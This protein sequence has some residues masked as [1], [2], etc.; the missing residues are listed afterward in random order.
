MIDGKLGFALIGCG[1]VS[2]NHLEAV[3]RPDF[4]GRLAAV[5]DLDPAKA[6][7]KSAKHGGVPAYTDFREML[8]K[9]P[10]VDVVQIA[11]PTGL[12][13]AHVV[14]VAKYGRHIVVEKPMALRVEDAKAMI[15]AVKKAK[16]RLFVVKQNRFNTAVQAAR[17]ALD[18]GRLGKLVMA[19]ARVRWRREQDYYEQDDWHGTW[20]LD[21]GV[22]SQQASHHLDLLQWFLGGEVESVRC[23]AATRLLD[24][25]VEDTAAATLLCKGGA[26]GVF[27]ATVCA[28]PDDMEAS[29]SLLGEKGSV[30]I[31]GKAVNKIAH[32]KFAEPRADDADIVQ[33]CSSEIPD[34][35]GHGH[36][37]YLRDVAEKIL[38]GAPAL[39]EG[40]EG[41]RNVRILTALYES[42][43]C[44][45]DRKRPGG[46][47]V[48]SRL[49]RG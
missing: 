2:R 28:R 22:M 32:W 17:R 21:G 7:A 42:A 48:K 10:E 45:G 16:R 9:H 43:A 5:C 11:T 13:A 18:E 40:D 41:L 39:V 37:P 15:A 27:E 6:A 44:G 31:A 4:P 26:L 46:R 12:H 29:I 20:A 30:I 8:T 49:G 24:I 47:I 1:R 19:T 38:T 35:Y 34:V 14:D 3:T 23:D 25:E 36:E 33:R